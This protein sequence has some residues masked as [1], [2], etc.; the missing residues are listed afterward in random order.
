VRISSSGRVVLIVAFVFASACFLGSARPA[1]GADLNTKAAP[2]ASVPSL[3]AATYEVSVGLDGEVFPVFANYASLQKPEDRRWPTISVTVRNSSTAVLRSRIIVEVPGWSDQ[4]I[5]L[6]DVPTGAV[7]T[8]RF[9]PAFLPRLYRN[10]EISAATAAITATDMAGHVTFA[11]TAPVRL[12]SV[13]DMYWGT[14][15]KFAPFIASWITPHDPRVEAV[16]SAAKEYMPGRRLPGYERGKSEA[17]QERSTIQQARAI[18][19]ALKQQGVSYVKSS[20]TFGNNQDWSERVRMPSESL[21]EQ[22]ANCIDGVVTYASLFEN[23]GMDPVVVLVPG[24]AYVGVRLSPHSDR[25]LYLE[26]AVTGRASFDV[27]SASAQ[28]NLERYSRSQLK[29]IDV[30]DARENGIYPMPR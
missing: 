2:A 8:Y 30:A 22:S 23:L 21:R 13:N 25:Y 29:V 5:Q 20:L 26:T 10:R 24:H 1:V 16:L 12:R 11:T 15:F 19:S 28:Q 17:V 14:D 6:I 3:S 9:A 4:E 27:A 7:Q 18:Y